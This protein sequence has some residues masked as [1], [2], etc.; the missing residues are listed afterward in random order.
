MF[1]QPAKK[2]IDYALSMLMH[3]VKRQVADEKNRVKS[4]AIKH[5]ALQSNRVIV[6]IADAADKIHK[7]SLDKA[8]PV[9]VD[10]IRRMQK[11]ATGITAWARPHLENL[12]NAVLSEIPPNGFPDDHQRIIRQYQA[13]FQQRV[14]GALR[15]VEIGY[16][17]GEGFKAAMAEQEEWI[18]ARAARDLLGGRHA[19]V[20]T[21]CKRAHAGMIKARAKRFVRS[22]TITDNIEI[23]REFWWAKGGNALTQNWEMGDFDTWVGSSQHLEAF[24]VTF[25]RSDIEQSKPVPTQAPEERQST[26]TAT[27]KKIFIGHGR[28]LIWLELKNHL[29]DSLKLKVDEFNSSA[30]AGISTADRLKEML[31][32]AAFAFL[33]MTAEDEQP[34][35]KFNARPN[36]IH[37]AGLFQ[38]RLGFEK[39]I[40]LLE[41][42]CE[43]F[44][45]IHGIGQIRFPPGNISAK[46]HQI[47]EVLEREKVL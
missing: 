11:P 34:D 39:A 35:G 41:D 12:S 27:G 1:E 10:F 21:I 22:G 45:N 40:V 36:V 4:E 33:V 16:L 26:M 37:E 17:N 32:N 24:G 3:E 43:E 42:G 28:S 25:R 38:G 6:I 30:T 31:H 13:V 8:K 19:A 2:D 15:E 5:G 23:P 9:L 47:R 44:S 20:V 18:S 29:Q 7:A 46:F 14:D